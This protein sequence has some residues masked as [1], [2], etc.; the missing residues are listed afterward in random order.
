MSRKSV[1]QITM[2]RRE[3]AAATRQG[4][5][6]APMSAAELE[7]H[8]ERQRAEMAKIVAGKGSKAR[9]EMKHVEQEAQHR[10]YQTE[11]PAA[12]T[13]YPSIAWK[14]DLVYAIPNFNV[15]YADPKMQRMAQIQGSRLKREGMRR[16]MPDNHVPCW[17]P[18]LGYAS[19]YVELK[20]HSYP[21]EEQRAV[22]PKL[23][24]A[25]NA[26]VTVRYPDDP[27]E[28]ARRAIETIVR[29]LL[30]VPS[31]SEYG[32]PSFTYV[33]NTT[34]PLAEYEVPDARPRSPR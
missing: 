2:S 27:I 26:V 1:H 9:R 11:I 7:A 33:H 32:H 31:F 17:S 34:L 3:I 23:A 6:A 22:F 4:A 21:S 19:L 16:G 14:L 15:N 12:Q 24:R 13:R 20:A 5:L 25:H 29:Y 18:E 30:G 10:L 8:T 28:L